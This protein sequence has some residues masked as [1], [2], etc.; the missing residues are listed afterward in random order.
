MPYELWILTL[1]L[2]HN[3]TDDDDLYDNPTDDDDLFEL[4]RLYTTWIAQ[5]QC[6]GRTHL[7]AEHVPA[8]TDLQDQ[9]REYV[10]DLRI[11]RVFSGKALCEGLNLDLTLS[12]T[13][14]RREFVAGDGAWGLCKDVVLRNPEF[15]PDL[16]VHLAKEVPHVGP[17]R[18]FL[19]CTTASVDEPNLHGTKKSAW[20]SL[21]QLLL[22]RV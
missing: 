3:P 9:N 5:N 15:L 14:I 6:L 16:T 7:D 8:W 10:A 17:L 21:F 19:D 11:K 20:I 13:D 12:E 1:R 2:N 22:I 18:A 4:Q